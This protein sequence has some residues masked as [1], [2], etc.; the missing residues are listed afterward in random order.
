MNQEI[1]KSTIDF[2]KNNHSAVFDFWTKG[3]LTQFS[4]VSPQDHADYIYTSRFIGTLG[5]IKK[6]AVQRFAEFLLSAP[7]SGRKGY[8]E[9]FIPHLSAYLLGALNILG[10]NG[11]SK[12][13]TT[14]LSNININIEE[15]IDLKTM[16]P[17]WPAK[18]SHHSW[19]VSHWIGG[20]PSIMLTMANHQ[21]NS[22]INIEMVNQVLDACNTKIVKLKT[23]LLKA[24]KSELIQKAFRTLYRLRHDPE[25]GDIGG[26]VHLL[27]INHALNRPYVANDALLQIASNGLNNVPFLESQPYCLDFDYIQLVRTILEQSPSLK[28]E[29]IIAR[30][31][32]FSHD[33]NDFLSNIPMQ[34]YTLHKLPGALATLHELAF[35][36]Q[37]N[38]NIEIKPID[39]I[40]EAYWL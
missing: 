3:D 33:L 7:L 18:W 6:S 30:A 32:Q 11:F 34:G 13:R 19:R 22:D 8:Q 36:L 27:W 24:Y 20:I 12:D 38:K 14:V 37:D 1:Q 31:K 15:L 25:H 21:P 2:L 28:N 23:G 10:N 16:L 35:L 40:K 26:I 4:T 39:I 17:L 9:R 5:N 29:H